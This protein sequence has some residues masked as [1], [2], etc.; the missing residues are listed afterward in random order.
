MSCME[1]LHT[2][3]LSHLLTP[4]HM[5]IPSVTT[6]TGGTNNIHIPSPYWLTSTQC[7]CQW[8]TNPES[9]PDSY[10]T[11]QSLCDNHD[12]VSS[13]G[14]RTFRITPRVSSTHVPGFSPEGVNGPLLAPPNT[15]YLYLFL[16]F[17]PWDIYWTSSKVR[18]HYPFINTDDECLYPCT[19]TQYV[20]VPMHMQC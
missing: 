6:V 7:K 13:L 8:V 4:S 19:H 2:H 11:T 3:I 15:H 20:N 18:A 12:R 14:N 16:C 5:P 1:C 10:H 9:I 17:K